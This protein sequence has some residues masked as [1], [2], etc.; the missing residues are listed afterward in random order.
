M[1]HQLTHSLLYF[2]QKFGSNLKPSENPAE[3]IIEREIRLQREREAELA[4]QRGYASP[5][6]DHSENSNSLKIQD[7]LDDY[8]EE[9]NIDGQ[10]NEITYEEAIIH[11]HTEGESLIA[12]ELRELREREEE[13][14]QQRKSI[15]AKLQAESLVSSVSTPKQQTESVQPAIVTKHQPKTSPAP[16]VPRGS[17]AAA[18]TPLVNVSVSRNMH[19]SLHTD[20]TPQTQNPAPKQET[21]I[22]REI[23]LARERENELR[24]AKGLPE[25]NPEPSEQD[26]TKEHAHSQSV[27]TVNTNRRQP[28]PQPDAS[29]RRFA[30]NRLQQEIL[31]QKK[32]E[33]ALRQ[34]GKIITTSEEHIQPLKYSEIT[35]QDKVEGTVK[36]NFKM[37]GNKHGTE[38]PESVQ[39][40]PPITPQTQHSQRSSNVPTSGNKKPGS[41]AGVGALNFSYREF[42]QTAE[43]KIE[44]ELREMREREEE[45]RF[46]VY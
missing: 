33:L 19:A 39:D 42:R 18:R 5:V 15:I 13:V 28:A 32:R 40:S 25:L 35:G 24:R 44:R 1:F 4:Q 30:S 7:R 6:G 37:P 34:E 9:D 41:G 3:S 36:R 43:S 45:L 23:R 38:S 8:G 46:V 21:P 2:F 16:S 11:S 31:D 17:V 26:I 29:I 20:S 14:R 22:E 12:R 27:P 10:Y